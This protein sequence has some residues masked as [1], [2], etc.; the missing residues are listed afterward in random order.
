[1]TNVSGLRELICQGEYEFS[2]YLKNALTAG[3]Q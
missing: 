3:N 1:M 2:A